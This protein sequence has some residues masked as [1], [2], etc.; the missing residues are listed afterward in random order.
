MPWH[1]GRTERVRALLEKAD[2]SPNTPAAEDPDSEK[3]AFVGL[4]YW[5]MEGGKAVIS[6]ELRGTPLPFKRNA[7]SGAREMETP[8]MPE[9]D[10]G[11]ARVYLTFLAVYAE[12]LARGE[13]PPVS[14]APIVLNGAAADA[15][16]LAR[17]KALGLPDGAFDG[18]GPLVKRL[19]RSD[20]VAQGLLFPFAASPADSPE[21]TALADRIVTLGARAKAAEEA[22]Q[23]GNPRH[24][25]YLFWTA[26]AEWAQR[27]GAKQDARLA[28][29]VR[30]AAR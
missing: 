9:R 27:Y 23:E 21:L 16:L 6:F 8:K 15:I 14:G 13:A 25:G 1:A 18:L 10:Y 20:K 11:P 2:A 29:L 3:H 30:A 17:A 5:G 28:Q 7:N 19:T 4:R 22:S 26:Y 24:E 12:A